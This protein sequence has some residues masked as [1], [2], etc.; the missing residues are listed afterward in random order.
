MGIVIGVII[1]VAVSAAAAAAEAAADAAA[2]AIAEAAEE[3]AVEAA[4][5]AAADAAAEAEAEGA[6]ER[7]AESEAESAAKGSGEGAHI[8]TKVLNGI[9]KLSKLVKEY[10]I[11]D[12]IF[13][14]AMDIIREIE[15]SSPRVKKLEKYIKVLIEMGQKMDSIR[16]WL[17]NHQKDT[18]KLEGIQ[19]P[20]DSGVLSKYMSPLVAGVANLKRLSKGVE[21]QNKQKKA[22]T[23]TQLDAMR[24]C[25][26]KVNKTF[27]SLAK[28]VNKKK[29]KV[30]VLSS[31]PISMTEVN[32]WKSE[33]GN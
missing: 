27:E 28:F 30:L 13:K 20:V 25:L 18:V 22:L 33:L 10:F 1:D 2:A 4:A 32:N 17:E 7:A 11:I 16:K 12:A 14:A 21:N 31:F 6:A 8:A 9:S 26:L 19:V 15:G 5:D 24:R 23:D 29:S 3:A